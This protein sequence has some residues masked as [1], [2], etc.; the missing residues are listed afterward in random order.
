MQALTAS[1]NLSWTVRFQ[2]TLAAVIS[3]ASVRPVKALRSG[4]ARRGLV[5]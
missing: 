2:K 1:K 3:A 5:S 4:R